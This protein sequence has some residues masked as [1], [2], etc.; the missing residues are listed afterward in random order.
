R[1]YDV[2]V[3]GCGPAGYAAAVRAWDFGKRVCLIERGRL[4]GAG[5]HDGALSSKTLW[6]VSRDYRR[7]LSR[8]RGYECRDVALDWRTVGAACAAAVE[9][10]VTQMRRQIDALAHADGRG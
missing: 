9:L 8:D 10:R 6:E 3:L 1:D 2:G 5:L 7:V 4:G